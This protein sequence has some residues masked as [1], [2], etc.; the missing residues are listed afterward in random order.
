MSH[1]SQL[2]AAHAALAEARAATKEQ[3]DRAIQLQYTLNQA[4]AG[5]LQ[6]KEALRKEEL[7][8]IRLGEELAG[9]RSHAE[10]LARELA[11]ERSNSSALAARLEGKTAE[12]AD[13]ESLAS[14]RAQTITKL[15][16]Q[17]EDCR[18]GRAVVQTQLGALATAAATTHSAVLGVGTSSDPV[19]LH[20]Q[21]VVNRLLDAVF[22]SGAK[23]VPLPVDVNPNEADDIG[24]PSQS[25]LTDV[26]RSSRQ[27]WQV[28]HWQ[29]WQMWRVWQA[30]RVWRAWQVR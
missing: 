20:N 29:V 2:E 21:Q 26:V 18:K 3:E 19:R 17:L 6:E 25:T 24:L 14:N 22:T 8:S 7:A 16:E 4:R 13:A 23:A 11:A 28:W 5:L 1:R 15:R 9:S 30:W 27:V 12:L 10:G